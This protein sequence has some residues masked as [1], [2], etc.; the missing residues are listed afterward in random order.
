MKNEFLMDSMK[1]KNQQAIYIY[2]ARSFAC[3]LCLSYFS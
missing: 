1:L 3:Y 2:L